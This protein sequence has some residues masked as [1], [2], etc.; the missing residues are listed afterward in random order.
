MQRRTIGQ[1]AREAGVGVETIRF[2]ERRGLLKQPV[3][4]GGRGYRHYDENAVRLLRYIRLGQAL[5][6]S[7]KDIEGL[8]VGSRAAPGGFCRQMRA[9]LEQKLAAARAELAALHRLE[10]EIEAVLAACSARSSKLPC[11]ILAG[12]GQPLSTETPVAQAR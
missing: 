12:L 10:G 5:G 11:P 8:L 3:R 6:L 7:L 2:Y 1:L 9:T 4:P